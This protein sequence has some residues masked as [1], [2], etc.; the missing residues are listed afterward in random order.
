MI[1]PHGRAAGVGVT[2]VGQP[3]VVLELFV[4]DQLGQ[5]VEQLPVKWDRLF[6][7]LH[8]G[9]PIADPG[10]QLEALPLDPGG[11]EVLDLDGPGHPLVHPR[12]SK[13]NVGADLP[14]VLLGRHRVLGEIQGVAPLEP[15]GDRHHLLADPGKGK[16]RDIIVGLEAG[17][18]RHQALAHGDHIIVGQKHP[19][20]LGSGPGCVKQEGHVVAM[21]AGGDFFE[22]VGLFR[23]QLPP[24]VHHLVEADETVLIVIPH[25][26]GVI[27]DDPLQLGTVVDDGQGLVHLFLTLAHQKPGVRMVDDVLDLFVQGV[28]EKP[29]PHCLAAEGP[30]LGP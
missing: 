18:H 21:A 8:V 7:E 17:I 29:D 14:D 13:H 23:L 20:G 30:H 24:E 1:R 4:D 12:R 27:P 10:P 6:L 3:E 26:L 25:P 2:D 19:L 16:V 15:A 11:I 28:L 22:Q 5:P 9:H